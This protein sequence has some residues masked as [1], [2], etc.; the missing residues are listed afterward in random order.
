MLWKTLIFI[1]FI[2]HTHM[3]LQKSLNSEETNQK[4]HLVGRC[5]SSKKGMMFYLKFLLEAYSENGYR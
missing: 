4:R 2:K 1:L 5:I 3:S